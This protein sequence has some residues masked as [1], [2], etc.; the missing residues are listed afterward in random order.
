MVSEGLIGDDESMPVDPRAVVS[1]GGDVAP[2]ELGRPGY[3]PA[4]ITQLAEALALTRSSTVVDLAG[5]GKLTRAL[6]PLAGRVVAVEPS[7]G[8]LRALRRLV[9]DAQ[10][11]AGSAEAMPLAAE[12]VDAV[13][14][15]EAFTGSPSTR[16]AR[17]SRGSCGPTGDSACYGTASSPT[18]PR[19]RGERRSASSYVL[20]SRPRPTSPADARPGGKRSRRW[21]SSRRSSSRP[22]T[23]S[24]TYR[25]SALSRSSPRGAGS[26]RCPTTSATTCWSRCARSSLTSPAWPCPTAPRSSRRGARTPASRCGAPCPIKSRSGPPCRPTAVAARLRSRDRRR[27]ARRAG[28]S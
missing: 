18:S 16:R 27:P 6:T 12:S 28:P 7:E 21:G 14:V 2:Y 22:S 25:L 5:T 19:R 13:V 9:P 23:T 15:G 17:G 26:L 8:L 20:T 4:A 11:V 1:F 24:M 3:P 10:A